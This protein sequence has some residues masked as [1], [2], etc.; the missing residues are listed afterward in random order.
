MLREDGAEPRILPGLGEKPLIGVIHL[1]PLTYTRRRGANIDHLIEYAVAEARK[2]EEA[3]FNAVIIENYGDKPYHME[4][5]DP[6]IVATMGVV[7]REVVKETSLKVGVNILRN[8]GVEALAAAYA[9]GA[10]FIRVNSYC[11]IRL[12][13]EGIMQPIGAKIEDLR[14]I[15]P[16]Y[17]AVFADVDVKHSSGL[18]P[19]EEAV[20]ECAIRGTMDAIIVSGSHTG[21][22]PSPGYVASIRSLVA[23]KP[24]LIGSGISIDNIEAYWN[25]AD[26]FIVGTSIKI[27]GT[28]SPI[29]LEKARKLAE[30]ARRLRQR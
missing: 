4:A 25:I 9:S 8:S 7:A 14:S 10:S 23:P 15:L 29:S 18:V 17:I 5:R 27:H 6:L 2:L 24:V 19:L 26:G 13:P 21:S 11:E 1:P 22:A 30:R 16:R 3:G 12:A 28:E 20:R